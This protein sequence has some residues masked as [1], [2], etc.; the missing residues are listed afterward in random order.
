MLSSIRRRK[1]TVSV[2]PQSEA[3]AR[4]FIAARQQLRRDEK[5]SNALHSHGSNHSLKPPTTPTIVEHANPLTPQDSPEEASY[6]TAK[7]DA[8]S[9][10]PAFLQVNAPDQLVL[11]PPPSE[12]GNLSDSSKEDESNDRKMFQLL[13]KPRIRYDVEVITK[14]VV[15]A[16]IAW[17]AV[18]G[19]PLLFAQLGIS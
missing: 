13:E 15:Y 3:D 9:I 5:A 16:G 8:A 10:S 12:N 18:E 19:N 2:G 1:R 4:E 7:T 6:L 11:T 14:L 17:L